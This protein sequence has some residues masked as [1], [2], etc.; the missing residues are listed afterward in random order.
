M[1]QLTKLACVVGTMF[2]S[3]L[4]FGQGFTLTS[5]ST[6][7]PV[8]TACDSTLNLSVSALYEDSLANADVYF[9]LDGNNFTSSQFTAVVWW[10]DGASSTHTGSTSTAGSAISWTPPLSHVYQGIGTYTV[11]L[12]VTNPMNNS[13]VVDTVNFINSGCTTAF[14]FASTQLDCDNDGNMDSTLNNGIPLI[15]SDGIN[16]YYATTQNQQAVF[17]SIPSGTYT[18]QVNPTWLAQ[19][20]YQVLSFL[21]N[22]ITVNQGMQTFTTLITLTCVNGPN[23]SCISGYV[24]CDQDTNGVLS[25]QD[26]LIL[27]APVIIQAG[28]MT[29]T[30]YTDAGG[31]YQTSL[32]VASGTPAVVMVNPNWLSVN[33][34]STLMGPQTVL[35]SACNGAD[36]LN[37]PVNCNNSCSNTSCVSVYV[38]CDANNNG[39]MDSGELPIANAPVQFLIN[40]MNQLAVV[41]TDSSGLAQYCSNY[42]LNQ[43]VFAQISQSWLQQHGYTSNNTLLTVLTS[44]AGTANTGYYGINCGGTGSQ[45]ADLWTTVTPWIGY[46][47]GQT[48]YIKLNIGNYGP[49]TGY[50]YTVTMNFP[51]G[52]T[53]VPSSINLP[54]YVISGNTITWNLTNA[55]PGY[56]YSDVIQFICPSGI[57]NGTAHYYTS[58]IAATNNTTDCNTNNNNG[59]LLQLVGSSYDPNDKSVDHETAINPATVETLT[60]TIRFQ[61]TGTAPAQNI[62]ILDTLSAQLDWATLEILETSH[63]M[64]LID[65]G[66][67]VKRFDFPQI[68][69]PEESANEPMSHG[70]VVY[71]IRE[72]ATNGIGSEIKNTAHIF[73]DWNDPIVTNTTYNVN[74]TLG[75]ETL[76]KNSVHVFPNPASTLLQIISDNE[77]QK[78]EVVDLTGKVMLLRTAQGLNEQ[79]DLNNFETGLY[80]VRLQTNAGMTTMS[81]FKK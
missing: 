55:Y 19:N 30:V 18:I 36:T 4:T 6:G 11:I 39:V 27:N 69:L 33:G 38:F 81:F 31:Y 15:I 35:T 40:T 62:Y 16:S 45:C 52:V 66:N 8:Y 74:S 77:L 3:C 80:L 49:G 29:Q 73:F 63:P 9:T 72:K 76:D 2:I 10:G 71:R 25:W 48:N 24:F 32:N 28:G 5:L 34:Y 7:T 53:P 20:G 41:Y 1:N 42:F 23:T 59:N 26:I 65:M 51:A 17:Y 21:G 64:Q 79:I 75:L 22:L 37:I 56:S 58:L 14:V 78:I 44:P 68:W 43:Y 12:Q 61:N 46:Y 13:T 57:P 70:H 50:T 54:G 47:Q 60:Y 67:G